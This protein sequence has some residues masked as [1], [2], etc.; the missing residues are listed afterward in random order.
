MARWEY[1]YEHPR[2]PI[3]WNSSLHWPRRNEVCVWSQRKTPWEGRKIQQGE[4]QKS[5]IFASEKLWASLI[6][7][8]FFNRL[9]LLQTART[10][11]KV[12]PIKYSSSPH[13]GPHSI[14]CFCG[15]YSSGSICLIS[16]ITSVLINRL[17]NKN[18]KKKTSCPTAGMQKNSNNKKKISPILRGWGWRE[19]KVGSFNE[20]MSEAGCD[21]P[22]WH[23]VLMWWIFPAYR[24]LK[25]SP[26]HHC[27]AQHRIP[28]QSGWIV[29][30]WL[31]VN[32][33]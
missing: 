33:I 9:S 14:S 24:A 2:N 16:C 13:A 27:S 20:L 7:S 23:E 30:F 19:G 11:C 3:Y 28:L 5:T 12:S 1:K 10:C 18:I 32:S 4:I 29:G 6:G 21:S 15:A 22:G 25:R 17:K 31:R 8:L 26:C